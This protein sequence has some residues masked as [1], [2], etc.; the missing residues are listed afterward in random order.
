[1]NGAVARQLAGFLDRIFLNGNHDPADAASVGGVREIDGMLPNRIGGGLA[2]AVAQV[3]EAPDQ[4]DFDTVGMLAWPIDA[5]RLV[6]K[7]LDRLRTRDAG[8]LADGLCAA[9]AAR[10]GR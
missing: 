7:S 3:R 10:D 6:L 5:V 8:V 2:S 1:M 9:I 4:A